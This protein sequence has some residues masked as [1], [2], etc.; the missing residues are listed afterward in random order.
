MCFETGSRATVDDIIITF[1]I[2]VNAL[3]A[4]SPKNNHTSKMYLVTSPVAVKNH[5]CKCI[6]V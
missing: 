5:V 3:Y 1:F 6:N 4:S 2:Y